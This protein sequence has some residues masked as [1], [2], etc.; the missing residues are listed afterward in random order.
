VTKPIIMY[1]DL[2]SIGV[3][4]LKADLGRVVVFGYKFEGDK[5]ARSLTLTQRELKRFDDKRLLVEAS[6]LIAKADIL[7]G[8]FA[9]VFDRRFF[10][11]RLLIHGLPPIPPTRLRDTYMIS[12]SVA[13]YS[14]NRL[15]HLCKILGFE[16]QKLENGWPMAW[17]EVMQGNMKS[18]RA[19]AK[20]CEGDVEALQELYRRLLPFDNAHPR[21]YEDRTKCGSCGGEVQYRGTIIV[22]DARF[23]RYV[24]K[25]CS[26]WG[27]E[28]QKV[29]ES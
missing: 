5:K 9:S 3:N 14:S 29:K 4:A 19:M 27:R 21:I 11:G 7:V 13:N 15:K 20:Y 8:H 6:K 10:Q 1:L 12:R 18:L 2:E 24:C 23:R 16:N 22:R 17:F 25:S 26:H 28:T